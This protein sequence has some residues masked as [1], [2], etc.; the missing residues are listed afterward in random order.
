MAVRGKMPPS[1]FS[2][3]AAMLMVA[4]T[5][6]SA[7]DLVSVYREALDSD[8]VFAQARAQQAADREQISITR[9]GLLPS[10]LLT[11]DVYEVDQKLETSGVTRDSNFR[12]DSALLSLS[13]PVYRGQNIATHRQA[14][15][16]VEQSEAQLA[17]AG[18]DLMLRV[19][20]AYFDVLLADDTL[21][22][23]RAE[24]NAI[25]RQLAFT[26]RN[27]A[28]GNATIVGVHEARAAFDLSKAQ[29]VEA[30]NQTRVARERLAAILGRTPGALAVLRDQP[31]LTVPEPANIEAWTE[32]ALRDNLRV[33]A[34]EH[35]LGA[36]REDVKRARAG[37]YPTLDLVGSHGY[38]D[39]GG[40]AFG[41]TS[42]TTTS[43]IGLEL[44][45]PIYSG[46]ATQAGVRQSAAQLDKANQALEE[47]RRLAK[48]GARDSWHAV[49]SGIARV[50]ALDQAIVSTKKALESTII[51][52]EAG[53]R[54]A[55]D[56]LNAQ[57]DYYRAKRDLAEA[58]YNYLV[59]RLQ[60]KAAV[61]TLAAADIEATNQ[62]LG[63][64]SAPAA[65]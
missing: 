19:S 8:P 46:G 7:D 58:R 28:V 9:A 36:G 39:L 22:F 20:R 5:H 1:P 41:I 53:V 11:G 55:V 10:I 38:N 42:E 63:S 18:Q 54:N 37:H 35:A 33:R 62:L 2:L 30:E 45:V 51:G 50:S 24:R 60:L 49:T 59:S 34:A 6:A 12:N 43:Q 52:A 29:E 3:F 61:G 4:T 56:V 25:S 57:R 27:F 31:P 26:E 15:F 48:L 14:R 44:A 16:L 13:Q 65:K 47:A 17:A 21:E 32:T 23:A 64:A 40:S